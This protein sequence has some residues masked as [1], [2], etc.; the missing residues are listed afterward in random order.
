MVDQQGVSEMDHC[1]TTG[2]LTD[3]ASGGIAKHFSSQIN[4]NLNI[5]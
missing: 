4:G 5:R 2:N 3:R 1:H